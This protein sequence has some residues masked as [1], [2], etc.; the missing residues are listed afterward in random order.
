MQSTPGGYDLAT[1]MLS[2]NH[3]I[4]PLVT[5]RFNEVQGRFSPNVRWVAYASDESDKFQ[6]YVRPF[7]LSDGQWQISNDGRRRT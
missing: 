7:P 5:S 2:K 1:A 4:T 6:V 3:A